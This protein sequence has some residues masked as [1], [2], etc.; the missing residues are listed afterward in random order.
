MN[1]L[2]LLC[3]YYATHISFLLQAVSFVPF[4]QAMRPNKLYKPTIAQNTGHWYTI[5]K[6]Y[7]KHLVHEPHLQ[8]TIPDI[9]HHIWVGSPLPKG[10]EYLRTTWIDYHPDWKFVFWTDHEENLKFGRVVNSFNELVDILKSDI[11][12]IVV[13]VRKV[14][15]TNQE[16]LRAT[17]NPGE[18]SDIIRY[19][20]LYAVGGVYLDT[21][22][23][24]LRSFEEIHQHCDFYAGI[25]YSDKVFLL[26]GMIGTIPKCPI[27][28]YCIKN[29]QKARGATSI[30]DIMRRTGQRLF[31][32]SFF[33]VV[34]EQ[35]SL[36]IV[37]FSSIYFYPWPQWN[38]KD[39][40]RKKIENWIKP[41]SVALHHWH[42]SWFR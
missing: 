3:I 36:R 34:Q 29:L 4:D 31:T 16:A 37:A 27:L 8:K 30:P 20:A 2:L 42:T 15:F 39:K 40:D 14:T 6:L 21:D 28:K 1:K 5:K 41:E 26:N 32:D 24:C 19:E 9:F 22:F 38:R 12:F 13:D 7:E 23:E 33:R 10:C 35:S 18:H 11:Q 17:K 25:S